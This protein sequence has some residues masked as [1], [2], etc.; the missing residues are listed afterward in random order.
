MSIADYRGVWVFAEQ[1][2]GELQKVSLEL[3]GEGRKIADKLGVKLTALLLGDNIKGLADILGRHGADEVLV[4]ENELLKHYT[5]DGY[6][7]VICDLANERKP[8]IL[9]IGATFIGRDLGPRV[10]ARLSTGLTADCTVLDVDVEK[11]DLLATRPAFGGNLMATIACPDHRPQ[12][13]TVRPGVFSK[14]SDEDRN[15]TVEEVEVKIADSDIRTKIV[16]IVKEA[17]DIVDISEANFI[18]SGGRGVGSKENFAI[19]EEL[20]EALGG[21]VAGS[22][23]AVENGWIERDYQVGQTGKTVR[24]TIYIA[25]GISGA[26]QHVAGMQDSD[27]IIAINKD[28]SAP[29]MQT[30]DYA[31]VG[32]LL[33]VVPEMTAQVKAMKEN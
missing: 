15:F 24:P 8:G 4:A 29:I 11:A 13:A 32:D 21:T 12:M 16:E 23:A 28:A 25:C 20:A 27:L 14:L 5:T 6:T 31:I 2:E 22:R 3:L 10:A 17:K 9:F 30:A 33:K 19:L 26:I 7:K 18:V 1:R